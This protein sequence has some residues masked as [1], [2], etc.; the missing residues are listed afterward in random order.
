MPVESRYRNS[1]PS[2]DD[3]IKTIARRIGTSKQGVSSMYTRIRRQIVRPWIRRPRGVAILLAALV[4]LT[5]S[6]AFAQRGG[7]G[8]A[9]VSSGSPGAGGFGATGG[10]GAGGGAGLAGGFGGTQSGF[11]NPA[12]MMIA[13]E[14]MQGLQGMGTMADVADFEG[15]HRAQ[16][17]ARKAFRAEQ[18]AQRQKR[19]ALRQEKQS[20][21]VTSRDRSNSAK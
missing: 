1:F 8:C 6:P 19:L 4:I 16:L 21:L 3:R 13:A 14:Q 7:A 9:G 20:R 5:S 18:A 2:A 12:Q 10:L 11:G 15:D 17:A